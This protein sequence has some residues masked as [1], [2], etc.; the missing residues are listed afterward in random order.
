MTE[1]FNC[2]TQLLF[3]K[4]GI[5]QLYHPSHGNLMRAAAESSKSDSLSNHSLNLILQVQGMPS[6]HLLRLAWNDTTSTDC[7]EI[8]QVED[9]GTI[10]SNLSA[11]T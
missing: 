2:K 9:L 4:E 10:H 5:T 3:K 8:D 6:S 11:N 1:P 7:M